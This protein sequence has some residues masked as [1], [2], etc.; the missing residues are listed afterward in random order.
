MFNIIESALY[1]TAATLL[2]LTL[3]VGAPAWDAYKAPAEIA[4]VIED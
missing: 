1:I 2:L 4:V 3:A